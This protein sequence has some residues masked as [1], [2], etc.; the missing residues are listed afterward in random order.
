VLLNA[1]AIRRTGPNRMWVEMA[2]RWAARGVPTVR[3]DL[4]GIGDA[5]GDDCWTGADGQFYDDAYRAE[6][7]ALLDTLVA[8]GL[9]GTFLLGGLC[10]GAYWSFHVAQDDPR[11]TAVAM[12]NPM[13]FRYDSSTVVVRTSRILRRVWQPSGWQKVLRGRTSMANVANVLRASYA[14]ATGQV[15]PHRA[16]AT[17]EPGLDVLR[18]KG[19]RAL[20]VFSEGEVLREELA[21][22]GL[23]R[24][25]DRW[26]GLTVHLLDGPRE[27]HTLQPLGLQSRVHALLDAYVDELLDRLGD[28]EERPGHLR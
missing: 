26:P 9:P 7:V 27:V 23:F 3:A 18:D 11:V 24:R 17:V 15:Q 12:L 14:R 19:V 4:H 16:D 20:L 22:E 1:G 10:S 25:L 13:T 28:D 2:R 6:V 21:E 5:G 8:R